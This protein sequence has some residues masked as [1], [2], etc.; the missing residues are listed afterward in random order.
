VIRQMGVSSMATLFMCFQIPNMR[1]LLHLKALGI[2]ALI[3]GWFFLLLVSQILSLCA[4]S[5]T[6]PYPERRRAGNIVMYG[7]IGLIALALIVYLAANGGQMKAVIDFFGLS[8]V[9]FFPVVGWI[10]AYIFGL[11]NGDIVSA[12]LFPGAVHCFSS[13]NE[14]RLLR[15]CSADDRN[16]VQYAA[17]SQR[18]KSRCKEYESPRPDREKRSDG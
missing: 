12:V 7:L 4:Y 16:A 11:I 2:F 15:G 6:A 3:S 10:N 5:L 8:A 17:G 14:F 1:N 9:S 18:G 13:K